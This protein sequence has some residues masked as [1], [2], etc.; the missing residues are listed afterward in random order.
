[1]SL[2]RFAAAPERGAPGV[3][4]LAD[5]DVVSGVDEGSAGGWLAASGLREAHPETIVRTETTKTVKRVDLKEPISRVARAVG[6][7]RELPRWPN[8]CRGVAAFTG[9]P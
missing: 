2:R 3:E 5:S 8:C 1:V 7:I 9:G 4:F 6:S